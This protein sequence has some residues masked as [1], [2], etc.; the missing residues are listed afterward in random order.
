[1]G[2]SAAIAAC[3]PG[4]I[5]S[6]MPSGAAAAEPGNL[7]F[8][9]WSDHWSKADVAK[10]KEKLGITVNISDLVAN[11][12]GLAKLT[13]VTSQLDLVSA[14]SL[15]VAKYFESGLISP[16]PIDSMDVSKELYPM[17]RSFDFWTRPEGYLAYPHGWS[18]VQ[19]AFDP[20][21][22][23]PAPDSWEVMIDPKY[24][25]R[26]VM[27]NQPSD[28]MIMSAIATGAKDAFNMTDAE[29]AT[30][31]SWLEKLKP[32][33]LK[34]VGQNSEAIQALADGSAWIAT[35]YLGAP[36]RV[37]EAKGPEVIAMVPKEGTIGYIDSEMMVKEGEN[38]VRV[39][40][41]LDLAKR[42]EYI[43]QN[44]LD[45]GRPLFNEAAYKL[46]VNNGHKD[47]ADRYLYNQPELSLKMTLKGP[48]GRVQDYITVFT[49]VFGG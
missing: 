42:A 6:L 39:L 33:I 18:P 12:D 23:S 2:T 43:A 11:E 4:G 48:G 32:N 27:E 34:L 47:R 31:G 35:Q 41:Y 14:D 22:V 45:N 37:K 36:D 13:Q 10:A 40:P 19:I 5:A 44:F 25:K 9:G 46:L 16:M 29:L 8:L 24:K 26:I 30:A 7:N 1:M 21:K 28:I 38:Q 20:A 49:S 17:A 3:S 15:W